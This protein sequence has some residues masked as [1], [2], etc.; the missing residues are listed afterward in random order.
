MN[1][2]NWIKL[3]NF[4][5]AYSLPFME[6]KNS[7]NNDDL[8]NYYPNIPENYYLSNMLKKEFSNLKL[9]G[10]EQKPPRG[11]PLKHQDFIRKY[12]SPVTPNDKM[13]IFHGLGT[14]KTCLAVFAYEFSKKFQN[15]ALFSNFNNNQKINEQQKKALVIVRGPNS[16]KN[17]IRELSN[18]CTAGD[19]VPSNDLIKGI[20]KNEPRR[21]VKLTQNQR[22]LR[23]MKLVRQNY[24][25]ETFIKFATELSKMSDERIKK[26]FSNT[27]IIID[28][29]HNLRY[30]PRESKVNLYDNFHRLLHL[31]ENTKI[32]LLS[33]TP[34]RDQPEEITSIAN[35]LLP[36]SNQ[37]DPKKFKRDFLSEEGFLLDDKKPKLREMFQGWISYVRSME[38]TVKK[39]F[40]G[41]V[42]TPFMRHIATVPHKMHEFQNK[43]YLEC[44][45][46]E[47]KSNPDE[48]NDADD[49]DEDEQSEGGEGLYEKSRQASL[50]VF[51]DR[52]FGKEGLNSRKWIYIDRKN[53]AHL[54]ADMIKELTKY[55]TTNK[56]KLRALA[57]YSQKYAYIIEQILNH[58]DEKVFV[59]STFVRGSGALVFGALL[60][61]FDFNHIN[62]DNLFSQGPGDEGEETMEEKSMTSDVE[63]NVIERLTPN[64]NRFAIITGT[65]LTPA[66]ADNLINRVYNHPDNTKGEYLKIII[67]SH[68]VGEG[69]SFKCVRQLHVVSP[70]WNNSV[71]EQA[72]GRGIRAFSHDML[73]PEERYIKIYRHA[74]VPQK[75]NTVENKDSIDMTMYKLSEDKD[76]KIKGIERVMKESAVDCILNRNRNIRLDLDKENSRACDY[77]N[78]NYVC[79]F[80]EETDL[81]K[82]APIIDTNNLF[83]ADKDVD[84]IIQRLR[85]LFFNIDSIDLEDIL[86][87][88]RDLDIPTFVILR[89]LKKM[90]DDSVMITTRFGEKCF[91]RENNN[92]YFLVN[93]LEYP[94]SFL[95]AGY[96][97][98]PKIKTE[99]D[100]INYIREKEPEVL[101]EH[102][103][104]IDKFDI[105]DDN[106]RKQLF[107]LFRKIFSPDI[108]EMFLEKFY[109]A[110]LEDTEK[111]KELREEFLENYGEY[112]I[113]I[114]D[115]IFSFYL[116]KSGKKLRVLTNNSD[117]K[118][119]WKDAS[120]DEEEIFT[121]YRKDKLEAMNKNIYGYYAYMEENTVSD[122][123]KSFCEYKY[124]LFKIPKS[125]KLKS[126]GEIDK[127]VMRSYKPGT[128]C[129]TGAFA[130]KGLIEMACDIFLVMIENEED[131]PPVIVTGT[132]SEKISFKKMKDLSTYKSLTPDA[133]TY[134]TSLEEEY[135]ELVKTVNE[136]IE[137]G[138]KGITFC[139]LKSA[140]KKVPEDIS[141]WYKMQSKK[142]KKLLRQLC[143]TIEIKDRF[144]DMLRTTTT[145]LCEYTKELFALRDLLYYI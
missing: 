144:A 97:S 121:N 61:I 17:F 104:S 110:Q 96:A 48:I 98:L 83:Y 105:D 71:T 14:G 82:Y 127:R 130:K 62:T 43:T 87:Y 70:H 131:I 76:V 93:R 60:T 134:L 64:K 88:L 33:A 6:S 135:D 126:T 3:E 13:L 115:F 129:N 86:F 72:I 74:S 95:L 54:T 116:Y 106:D 51:P 90:I 78:C 138:E 45:Q 24:S 28:E 25:I 125:I 4:F 37:L 57:E 79:S 66:I 18:F 52:K 34:M 30:Q 73:P 100:L 133:K 114:D 36:L 143:N 21:Y 111:N 142:G 119:V 122:K 140:E 118:K 80:V 1:V 145:S 10:A 120:P 84:T 47:K 91:L 139:E 46:E 103:K 9:T 123:M 15:S 101:L 29:V 108:R 109:I 65:N 102:I 85:E 44:W 53:V 89:S 107:F 128:E 117:G 8:F 124:K 5:P 20:D 40:M 56:D 23:T 63:E 55:G 81:E 38:S 35:L 137:E 2:D 77:T 22:F 112:I 16:K 12:L 67:G 68:V 26:M 69:L 99:S 92:L 32:L 50:F 75:G 19:Y 11:Q 27:Y 141:N 113:T 7:E 136:T 49:D 94:S 42:Q 59:Y 58:P 31:V 132:T 41:N 39:E